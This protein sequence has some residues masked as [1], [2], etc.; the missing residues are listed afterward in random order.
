[1]KFFSFCCDIFSHFEL[2]PTGTAGLLAILDIVG[3]FRRLLGVEEAAGSALVMA[4]GRLGNL[5][6]VKFSR[7]ALIASLP[8]VRRRGW[9]WWRGPGCR[10]EVGKV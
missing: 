10:R 9:W 7:H 3:I 5:W 1:M 4:C 8:S 6:L 2:S